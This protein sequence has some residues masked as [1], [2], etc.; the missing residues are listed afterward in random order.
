M[1]NMP[2]PPRK[3]PNEIS[4]PNR[5]YLSYN[6]VNYEAKLYAKLLS[7]N[8]TEIIKNLLM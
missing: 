2:T 5:K 7:R 8:V 1:E 6:D 4:L 3:L